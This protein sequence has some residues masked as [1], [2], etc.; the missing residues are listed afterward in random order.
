MAS[1]GNPGQSG[2]R[3][4]AV[5][6]YED[7]G[8]TFKVPAAYAGKKVRCG[9]CKRRFVVN[10]TS[11]G[12]GKKVDDDEAGKIEGTTRNVPAQDA[13]EPIKKGGDALEP[14]E[15][16]PSPKPTAGAGERSL[17]EMSLDTGDAEEDAKGGGQAASLG[18]LDDMDLVTKPDKSSAAETLQKLEEDQEKE[19]STG[20]DDLDSAGLVIDKKEEDEDDEDEDPKAKKKR[21]KKKEKRPEKCPHCGVPTG[22]EGNRC[23]ICGELYDAPVAKKAGGKGK[24]SFKSVVTVAC[25]LL[26][27]VGG[28]ILYQRMGGDPSKL[29]DKAREFAS[30]PSKAVDEAKGLAEKVKGEARKAMSDE[31]ILVVTEDKTELEECESP[32]RPLRKGQPVIQLEASPDRFKVK[33]KTPDG[34]FEGWI[35]QDKVKANPDYDPADVLG[36]DQSQPRGHQAAVVGVCFKPDGKFAASIAK[37]GKEVNIWNTAESKLVRLFHRHPSAATGV[38]FTAKETIA[39]TAEQGGMRIWDPITTATLDTHP[40]VKNKFLLV[41]DGAACLELV[42]G[43]AKLWQLGTARTELGSS[44]EDTPLL[45]VRIPTKGSPVVALTEQGQIRSYSLPKLE[46][47][48]AFDAPAGTKDFDLSPDGEAV[49]VFP[50]DGKKA[51]I[52]DRRTGKTRTEVSLSGLARMVRFCGSGEQVAVVTE[53]LSK[54]EVFS[55]PSRGAARKRKTLDA[56][57]GALVTALAAS[58][59]GQKL[60]IGYS[61][62]AVEFHALDSAE[63]GSGGDVAGTD[64]TGGTTPKLAPSADE[65]KAKRNYDFVKQFLANK[66]P[67]NAKTYYLKLVKEC[68]DSPY[69]AQAREELEKAGVK[70]DAAP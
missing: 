68:P 30:D 40:Y 42:S 47:K 70:L 58:R 1:S 20:I 52:L 62:G 45:V 63:T 66:M 53:E 49:V 10:P 64:G 19:M 15:K 6:P 56:P 57:E 27:L 37:D 14:L 44:P 17:D 28:F 35:P 34:V 33:V 18:S 21:A 36:Y 2:S 38:G 23:P 12:K 59:D 54:V 43:R 39:S 65:K 31:T 24:K 50:E 3:I 5:C 55:V 25:L 61:T 13:L 11:G 7:C 69:T 67:D 60:A 29:I 16:S 26:I 9:K 48:E 32:F 4:D 22:E 46:P 8:A 51:L 41:Q